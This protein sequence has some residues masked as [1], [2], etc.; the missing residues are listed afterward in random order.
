MEI[1]AFNFADVIPGDLAH[2][3]KR[4]PELIEEIELADQV[5]L[6]VYG[7]GEHHHPA[8][9]GPAPAVILAAAARRTGKIRLTSAVTVLSADDPVRVFE[10]FTALDLVSGGRAEIMAGRG[11]FLDGFRL[12]GHDVQDYDDLFDEKLRLLLQLRTGEPVTWSGRFRP[13]LQG[14]VIL[15]RPVQEVLPVRIAVGGSPQSVVRA[16]ELGLPLVIGT[17]GG[18]ATQFAPLTQLY[19]EALNHYQQPAQP[20]GVTLHGFVADTSQRAADVYYTAE[21][22]LFNSLAA[23][24]GVA[25][26]TP[27]QLA[28]RDVPGSMGAV[29]S[30]EQV[31]EK[32]LHHHEVFGHQ[33]TM[34]QLA[35]GP[36]DH[37]QVMHA[38]E[39]LGTRVAPAVRDEI[40]R[41]E[42]PAP[43]VS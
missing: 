8:F 29:G 10:Q 36:I 6:D 17:I 21:S 9:A 18:L 38:I 15:P 22:S 37:L 40:A 25:K 34:L 28:A 43:V 32:L 33:R 1:G 26:V 39:L 4:V 42:Q 35:I 7:I 19:R 41:R 5:G 2:P 3:A 20:I 12:F 13:P 31:V 14:E 24:R 11:A 23:Q 30:P 27:E 16:G